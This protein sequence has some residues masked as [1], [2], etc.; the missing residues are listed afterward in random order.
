MAGVVE[1]DDLL[2]SR[3][4]GRQGLVDDGADGVAGLGRRDRALGAGELDGGVEHLSLGV[5]DRLHR[6]RVCTRLQM[7]GASPW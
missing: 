5:G 1:Q 6:A 4:L 2:A 7:I 3:L